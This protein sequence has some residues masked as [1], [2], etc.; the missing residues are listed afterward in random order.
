MTYSPEIRR[1]RALAGAAGSHGK[2]MKALT[3][4]LVREYLEG[5]SGT[6][7]MDELVALAKTP[8]TGTK[9]KN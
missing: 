7:C 4:R 3:A 9:G 5:R 1:A 8:L 6:S 2:K